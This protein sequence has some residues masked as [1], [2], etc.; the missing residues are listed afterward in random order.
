[1]IVESKSSPPPSP[2]SRNQREITWDAEIEMWTCSIFDFGND[3]FIAGSSK[4]NLELK[5]DAFDAWARE[6]VGKN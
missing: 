2:A 4:E 1:M 5:L 6:R 3:T